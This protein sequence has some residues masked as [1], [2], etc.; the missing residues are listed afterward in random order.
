VR[1]CQLAVI[2]SGDVYLMVGS[3]IIR[4]K[5]GRWPSLDQ[6]PSFPGACRIWGPQAPISKLTSPAEA[7]C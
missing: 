2:C 5:K 6:R 7:G 4:Q 1:E 3:V